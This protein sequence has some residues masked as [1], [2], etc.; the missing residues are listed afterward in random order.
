MQER[1]YT[2]VI[3][4]K[5]TLAITSKIV[6]SI[7]TNTTISARVGQ[8]IIDIWKVKS[9]IIHCEMKMDVSTVELGV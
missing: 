3:S 8:T 7:D 4:C 9:L 1:T 2:T 6:D 5:S